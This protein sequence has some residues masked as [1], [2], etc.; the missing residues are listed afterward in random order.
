MRAAALATALWLTAL[1][2][3][4]DSAS[5]QLFD[6]MGIPGLIA[7][8][9]KDGQQTI[10]DL[11][12]GF[13]DGQGG[14]V[15]VETA[16]RLYDP[17]RLETELRA[18]FGE[19]LDPQ[20]ARQ[21]VVFFDSDQGQRIVAIEVEARRA[22]VDDVLEEAA[23][24]ASDTASAD[25]LRLISVRDLVEVNTD[26]AIAA[27]FAFYDG[28]SVAAPGI[29]TPEIEG[30]RGIVAEDTRAWITGYYM[31]VASA[32][33]E[34]DL[35]TYA[36]FWETDVG[37]GVDAAL[38]QAFEQSYVTLSHGLGQLVGRMLPQNDL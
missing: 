3:Q 17:A 5:D 18:Q 24:A 12:A 29:D 26:I 33:Q 20:D 9:A 25:V 10:P 19:R 21:A 36:A 15:F 32:L 11:N 22:M 14:D 1:A 30:Q 4:A 8:F 38:S 34:D 16:Q 23:K 6:A 31:L 35:D 2:A 37:Q 13:L 7:A 28:L 27:R